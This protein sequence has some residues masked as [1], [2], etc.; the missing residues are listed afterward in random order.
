MVCDRTRP[1]VK[2]LFLLTLLICSQLSAA[3]VAAGEPLSVAAGGDILMGTTYPV[4]I[5]PPDDGE[6]IFD[7]VKPMLTRSDIVLGNLEGPLIDGGKAAK[8]GRE[9]VVRGQCYEFRMPPRYARHL[10]DAGFN[11]IHIAN[12]HA[13]DF[14]IEGLR[15][16]MTLLEEAGIQPL[17]GERI[18]SFVIRGKKVAA[19]GFSFSPASPYSHSLRD[20]PRARQVVRELKAR[21]DMVIVSFHGGAEGREAIEVTDVEEAYAGAKRGN[22]VRF[23]R[24]VI[25]AGADLVLG[26]GPHVPRAFELYRK[27][28]IAYSLGNFLTYG[29]FNLKGPSGLSYLLKVNLE[30]GTGNFAGAKVIPLELFSRRGIPS[31]DPAGRAVALIRKLTEQNGNGGALN[32][33]DD[34]NLR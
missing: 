9:A 25:D 13:F 8:C 6:G 19:V 29:P 1:M 31:F 18:G 30:M 22:V 4:E 12:N 11:L 28:L 10:K 23:S 21:N 3:G 7:A 2:P 27:K 34:G 15:S 20:T 16:T 32:F 33:D 5:L 17:G 14:G 24:A 26:H